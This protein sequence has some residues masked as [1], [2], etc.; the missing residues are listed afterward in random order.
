MISN[1]LVMILNVSQ[2]L[3]NQNYL[4]KVTFS[5]A[6]NTTEADIRIYIPHTHIHAYI[7]TY[8]KTTMYI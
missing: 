8:T 7:Y 1:L 3:G 4:Y 6:I 5:D 2:L